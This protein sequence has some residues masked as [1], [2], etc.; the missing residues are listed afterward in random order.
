MR[1]ALLQRD[2][3]EFVYALAV[4]AV[5]LYSCVINEDAKE[6]EKKV[7]MYCIIISSSYALIGT[8]STYLCRV[9][10]IMM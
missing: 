5:M 9:F 4:K 2:D 7:S 3:A 6:R 8:N 10:T 1:C